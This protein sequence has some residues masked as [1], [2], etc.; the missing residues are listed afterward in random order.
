MA[1]GARRTGKWSVLNQKSVTASQASVIR[2]W[3]CQG[4]R[5][6]NRDCR[7]LFAEIDAADELAGIGLQAESPVP[8]FA[9][10]DCRERNV[11]NI[12]VGGIG[13]VGPGHLTRE[14]AHDFQWGKSSWTCAAS[15]SSNGRRSRRGVLVEGS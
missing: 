6:R 4:G 14:M 9:A 15:A 5:A 11:A 8:G 10:L 7:S 2:P 13:G 1:L 12:E 3:R